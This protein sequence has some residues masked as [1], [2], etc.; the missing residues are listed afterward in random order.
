MN[1]L[2]FLISKIIKGLCLIF[3]CIPIKKNKIFTYPMNKKYYC[4]LK[5]IYIFLRKN[6]K[7]IDIIWVLNSRNDINENIVSC[8]NNSIKFFY[9]LMT[10]KIV[11]FN[12]GLPSYVKKR[13]RQIYIETWHGGGAY[14]KID[15]VYK[16]IKNRYEKKRRLNKLNDIDYIISSCEKFSE[17]F[18]LDTGVCNAKFLPYGMPRNDM[19]FD[20]EKLEDIFNK[21]YNLYNI[22]KTKKIILYAPTFRD[23]GFKNDLDIDRILDNLYIKFKTK[24]VFMLRSHPHIVNKIFKKNNSEDIID[25]SSYTDMQELLYVADI[26]ITDYSS[27]MWDFS[28]MYKPC[29]IYANDLDSYKNER[30][31]HTPIKEWPFPLST[32]SKELISNINSFNSEMYIKDV[33][34]HH[35]KLGSYENGNATKKICELINN[36]CREEL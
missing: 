36:I 2:K 14:K 34:K 19:F 7:N 17:V 32:N 3:Y 29:F 27:C 6:Y 8:K 23:K 13:S 18:K 33:K 5:Y 35:E 15:T 20:N 24:Y 25:V 26:L 12:S 31:F 16:N 22:D 10:S 30:D 21:I 9:H 11:L 1:L 4:N 28:L